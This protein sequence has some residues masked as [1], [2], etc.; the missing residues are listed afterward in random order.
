MPRDAREH[1]TLPTENGS[2]C[3]VTAPDV[4]GYGTYEMCRS[5]L[6]TRGNQ[7][8]RQSSPQSTVRSGK[9][10]AINRH[11]NFPRF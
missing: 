4:L 8:V 1:S 3:C 5:Y 7:A 2:D 11:L 9:G 6:I 10:T